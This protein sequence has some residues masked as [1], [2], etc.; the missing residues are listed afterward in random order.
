MNKRKI[1]FAVLTLPFA[2]PIWFVGWIFY[3]GDSKKPRTKVN[4]TNTRKNSATFA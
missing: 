4:L 2:V 3:W 1:A